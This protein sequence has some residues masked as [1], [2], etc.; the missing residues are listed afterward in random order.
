MLAV[1]LIL[2]VVRLPEHRRRM[3][4]LP[5]LV[6]W[7]A[8]GSVLTLH[9]WLTRHEWDVTYLHPSTA[10]EALVLVSGSQGFV[11]DLSNGSLSAMTAAAREAKQQGA[12]ELAAYML[13]HYHT[14]TSGALATLLE[15]EMIRELWVP[16]PVNEAEY[17]QLL[18]CLE[19]AESADVPVFL[20]ESG[21][22]LRVFGQGMLIPEITA[23]KR[24]EQPVLLLTLDA[25]PLQ[26]GTCDLVYCGSAVFE[27]SLADSAAARV[28]QAHT[29]IFGGHGPLFKAPYGENLHLSPTQAIILSANGDAVAWF[30]YDLSEEMTAWMGNRRFTVHAP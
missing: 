17:Y 26:T 9:G 5:I 8:L 10:S 12:T 20:Y 23:I 24:S 27:S 11:C 16:R 30:A 6:G 25:S 28:S 13:T 22:T 2:L 15:R 4:V 7:M 19:T 21:D 1:T 14:R 18:S 3:V 29:V